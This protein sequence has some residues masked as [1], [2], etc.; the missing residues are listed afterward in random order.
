MLE[1]LNVYKHD[2]RIIT[3]M[4]ESNEISGNAASLKLSAF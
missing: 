1:L 2:K 4:T 3:K